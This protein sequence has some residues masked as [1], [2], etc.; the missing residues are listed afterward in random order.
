MKVLNIKSLVKVYNAYKNAEKVTALDGISL[1]VEKGEFI[2]IMGPSGS[3]KTTMLNVISG[4]DNATS[5]EV[6]I[7]GKDICEMRKE[8]LIY[9]RRKNLGYIF[10]D[11]NLLDSLTIKENIALPL[12]V[13]NVKASV[14]DKKLNNLM[15]YFGIDKIGEKY[16]FHI[17]GGQKQRAAAARALI[18]EPAL[19]LAD[20]PTGNLDSK[21]SNSIMTTLSKLNEEL[22]STVLMV[23]HDAFA[24]SFCKKVIFVKD[25]QLEM[26]IVSNGDRKAFFDKILEVQS[27]LMGV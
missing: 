10:Q 4:I 20:E 24:A 23:T 9:F 12:I 7:N 5:G 21:S 25:G 27:V 3:G 8:E 22:N 1:S 13:D 18:N 11:F 6:F 14:I 16:P 17:S 26:E 15:N 2:G 19:I